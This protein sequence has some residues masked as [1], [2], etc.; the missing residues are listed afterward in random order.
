MRL[1]LKAWPLAFLTPKIFHLLELDKNVHLIFYFRVI[2]SV[3][4]A[5][6]LTIISWLMRFILAKFSLT[7][8]GSSSQAS[9]K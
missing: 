8:I 2:T 3:T 5:D 6:A 4:D 7:A 1:Q 9:K